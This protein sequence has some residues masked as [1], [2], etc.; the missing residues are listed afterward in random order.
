MAGKNWQAG[1]R[2]SIPA[3]A[4][5]CLIATMLPLG[6]AWAFSD[7]LAPASPIGPIDPDVVGE[8]LIGCIVVC[9]LLASIAVWILSA[10]HKVKG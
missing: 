7:D 3:W 9:A 2:V 8:L 5:A 4:G 6:R 1:G 10:L